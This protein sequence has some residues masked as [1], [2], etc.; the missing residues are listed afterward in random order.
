MNTPEIREITDRPVQDGDTVILD[1]QGLLDGVAFSGG[2]AENYELVIGSGRFIP[3]FE[4]QLIGAQIGVEKR[5]NLTFPESYD[6]PSLAGQ[7]VVFVVTVHKITQ[8]I[9]PE[10]SDDFVPGNIRL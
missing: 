3:G 4:E 10:W 5:L 1:F 7:P 6:E 9:L 2:T 8:A